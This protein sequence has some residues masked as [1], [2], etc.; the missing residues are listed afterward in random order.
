MD[1]KQ[2]AKDMIEAARTSIKN[3]R[4]TIE[5]LPSMIARL[6]AGEG[7]QLTEAARLLVIADLETIMQAP[8]PAPDCKY[9]AK[10]CLGGGAF[11]QAHQAIQDNLAAKATRIAAIGDAQMSINE[12]AQAQLDGIIAAYEK[13]QITKI[14]LEGM[15]LSL[16]DAARSDESL[17]GLSPAELGQVAQGI[18]DFLAKDLSKKLVAQFRGGIV[19]DDSEAKR[20]ADIAA[21]KAMNPEFA[22]RPAPSTAK[23]IAAD[24]IMSI[25]VGHARKWRTNDHR[26]TA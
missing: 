17:A 24:P 22:P 9:C 19:A 21:M 7:K 23:E 18:S 25:L 20:A 6:K 1:S 16:S 13:G 3:G 12:K 15:H 10:P 8:A 11:C 5:Q 26:R 2:I 14:S 4:L